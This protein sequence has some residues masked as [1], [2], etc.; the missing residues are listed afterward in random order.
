MDGRLYRD[1]VEFAAG[2][3]EWLRE[4]AETGTD[5]VLAVFAVLSLWVWWRARR[6]PAGAMALALLGPVA[7]VA[8]Y[9]VSEVV[10]VLLREE[11]PCRA[12]HGVTTLVPC[13]P[14]GD[15][16]LPSNHATLAA[17]AAAGLMI[18]WRAL[19]P[20]VV[21][22]ALLSGMSRVF[23]GVHYPHDVAVGLLLGGVLVPVV[24]LALSGPTTT[25]VVR[26]RGLTVLRPLLLAPRADR[27]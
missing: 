3:P 8:A 23:V 5:A 24:V 12:L 2:T 17:G 15:W 9:A 25:L 19:A 6:G 21:V 20:Y 27:G 10:K 1:V 11:R 13:P 26:L 4:L 7:T 16:S 22:L 14:Y 18:A